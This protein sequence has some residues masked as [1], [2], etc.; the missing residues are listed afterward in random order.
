MSSQ[1]KIF[2]LVSNDLSN[3][4]RVHRH[5][6]TMQEEGYEVLLLGRLKKKTNRAITIPFS[7][8][9]FKLMFE[10]SALFYAALNIRFFIYLIRQRPE[11][12]WANDLDT[13]PAAYLASRLVKSE[14]IYDSHEFFT[15][16]PELIDKKFVTNFWKQIE[17]SLLPRIKTKIT[18]NNSIARLYKEAYNVDFEVIRNLSAAIPQTSQEELPQFV[19]FSYDQ[20][21]LIYQGQ[22]N[23]DRGLEEMIVA[24]QSINKLNFL[25]VGGGDVLEDLISKVEQF[26]L[27]KKI[28]FTGPLSPKLLQQITPK[29]F[30]GI[31]LEKPTNINYKYCLPNKVFDYI[32]AEI[33]IIAYPN[34]EVKALVEQYKIGTLINNHTTEEIEKVVHQ[35]LNDK[36]HYQQYKENIR[37]AK[38]ELTWKKEAELL[39]GIIKRVIH[40]TSDQ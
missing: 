28:F 23:K 4:Q 3:D 19:G 35:L 24:M 6:K 40:R 36:S 13:L 16:V 32:H 5:A 17:R 34:P 20:P 22:V 37:R 18:V 26:D 11:V 12:I 38:E 7:H 9:R 8:K 1:Q 27:K 14:L 21:F 15:G 30:A 31:S 2:F 33:P 10:K 25:I 39:R 29:A